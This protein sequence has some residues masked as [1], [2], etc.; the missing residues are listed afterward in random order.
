MPDDA[1]S[2]ISRALRAHF[3]EHNLRVAALTFL[4]LVATLALWFLLH[5]TYRWLVILGLTAITGTDAR[6]PAFIEPAFWSAAAVL[7]ALAWL[8]RVLRADDRPRDHKTPGEIAWEIIL[9]IPRATLAIGATLSA[10]QHLT[11]AEIE[12]AASLVERLA[13]VRRLPLHA[14]PLEIPD[15]ALREKIVFALQL[16]Q[17]IDIRR[18]D[19]ELW[20][21]LNALRPASLLLTPGRGATGR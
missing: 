8:D 3:A 11:R 10:W 9:A 18:E 14:L 6:V 7:L 1:L 15:E 12:T 17:V 16:V 2:E 4:T 21:G 5:A 19:R 20:I 13:H